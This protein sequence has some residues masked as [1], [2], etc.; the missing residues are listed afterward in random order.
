MLIHARRIGQTFQVAVCSR[1][2]P[3]TGPQ[4]TGPQV[5]QSE[6]GPVAISVMCPQCSESPS[7]R[8]T[9]GVRGRQQ[10]SA[11]HS[12][13]PPWDDG[14]IADREPGSY[15]CLRPGPHT[16]G[17]PGEYDLLYR[18]HPKACVS[19]SASQQRRPKPSTAPSTHSRMSH[20]SAWYPR[21][22]N[23]LIRTGIASIS[24][25]RVAGVT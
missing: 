23:V 9:H 14:T 8:A 6:A 1:T 17:D 3:E 12:P 5:L 15:T 11:S 25:T 22:A 7:S 13:N 16:C 21:H 2:F 20:S 4:E 10:R 18:Y 24:S 19:L